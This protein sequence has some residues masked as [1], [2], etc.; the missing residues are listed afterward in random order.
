MTKQCNDGAFDPAAYTQSV[1]DREGGE[2]GF[3]PN[4]AIMALYYE[5]I[6]LGNKNLAKHLLQTFNSMLEE[7]FLAESLSWLDLENIYV[8]RYVLS[9]IPISQHWQIGASLP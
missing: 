3:A 5:A 2:A 9:Y 1:F 7:D 4:Y 6:L 8:W